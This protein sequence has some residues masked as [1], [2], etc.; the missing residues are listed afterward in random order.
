M[1]DNVLTKKFPH[2]L[3]RGQI[4]LRDCPY[5][6]DDNYN[7]EASIEK[8]VFHCW[9]CDAAGGVGKLFSELGLPF[10]DDGMKVS[11]RPKVSEDELTLKP[12]HPIL[13]DRYSKFLKSRGLAK[14]DIKTY[15][16]L[17][18]DKGKFKGKA[19]FP[20]YEGDKLVY[21][22]ARDITPKGKYLNVNVS[23]ASVLP[24]FPGPRKQTELYLCEGVMDAISVNKLG[25][26][27]CVLLGTVL[28]AEQLRKIVAKGYKDVVV[29]L[30]G[31]VI[32]KAIQIYDKIFKAGLK[33]KLASFGKKDD[34]NSLFVKDPAELKYALK[35]AKEVTLTDRVKLKMK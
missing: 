7:I 4:L 27:S 6:G 2:K 13:W 9:I 1:W 29:C 14:K 24:Y 31:D 5:C 10:T 21:L 25:Y 3:G 8:E 28:S 34:P 20:L 15:N 11:P 22:V 23:R 18:S 17:I 12:F 35:N 30:D 32:K 19:I 16:I 33:V 26:V